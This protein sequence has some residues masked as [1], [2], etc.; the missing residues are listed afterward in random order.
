[1]ISLKEELDAALSEPLSQDKP[2]DRQISAA[3]VVTEDSAPA[4]PRTD[5][6]S[7]S[8]VETDTSLPLMGLEPSKPDITV[9]LTSHEPA[10]AVSTDKMAELMSD[11]V[12]ESTPA[13]GDGFSSSSADKEVIYSY[14]SD[15]AI[16]SSR[17]GSLIGQHLYW[18][19]SVTLIY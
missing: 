3:V 5:T 12:T 7:A 10:S 9:E 13:I 2:D 1:M 4:T 16:H 6:E 8:S 17:L 14:D 18:L 15:A 19:L 11:V